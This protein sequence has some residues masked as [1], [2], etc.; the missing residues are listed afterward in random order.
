MFHIY[1]GPLSCG[2]NCPSKRNAEFYAVSGYEYYVDGECGGS[3]FVFVDG[4]VELYERY[5]ESDA[6]DDTSDGASG[7]LCGNGLF[8]EPTDDL[9]MYEYGGNE[10]I[11]GSDESCDGVWIAVCLS[12]Q[13]I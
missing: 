2:W 1:G 5:S 13:C 12:G 8:Y 3:E 7:E 9:G 6:D 4:P 11:G 10:R